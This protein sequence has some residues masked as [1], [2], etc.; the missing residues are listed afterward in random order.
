MDG[1]LSATERSAAEAH[2]SDCAR[3]QAMLAA[4][5]RTAPDVRRTPSWIG[6]VRWLVPIAAAALA[7][8]VWVGV[9][10]ESAAP[11]VARTETAPAPVPEREAKPSA[12]AQLPAEPKATIAEAPAARDTKEERSKRATAKKDRDEAA[13]P[14]GGIAG[15]KS[16]VD[17]I[18]ALEQNRAPVAA[19]P[20]PP[21]AAPLPPPVS[22]AGQAGATSAPAVAPAVP[23]EPQP[24]KPQL[25]NEA[26]TVTSE[27]SQV[28][29][30]S[31][32]PAQTR[33]PPVEVVSPER[34][35]RWR[36]VT[37]GSIQ[38][39]V[40]G[41]LSWRSSTTGTS[42]PLRAGSAPS[43]TVCWLVGQGGLVLLTTDG[44]NW[45]VRPFPEQVDLTDVSAIDARNATVTTANRRRFATADGGA[46][47]SPLQEN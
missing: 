36:A 2:A 30:R 8:A 45:Q 13:A 29:R 38:H 19:T 5:V 41:G 23:P 12:I 47:W 46:T 15:S 22:A 37:P 7:I 17:R 16:T 43:R 42:V 4:I 6:S 32:L 31:T 39:S 33:M 9:T 27:A 25:L 24:A 10:R 44:Q 14:F 21:P 40:D 35:Y 34:S 26:V 28:G 1:A 11:Q 20:P 3:C 18:D